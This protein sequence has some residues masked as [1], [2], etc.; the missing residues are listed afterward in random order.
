MHFNPRNVFVS[1]TVTANLF[2]SSYVGTISTLQLSKFSNGSYSLDTLSVNNVTTD[3]PSWLHKDPHNGILYCLNEGLSVVNGSISSFAVGDDGSLSLL[4]NE[5]TI[6]GPVSSVL[7]NGGKSLA[8]AHYSGASLTTHNIQADGTLAPLQTITFT[9][10]GPGPDPLK[11]QLTPHPHEAL[12]DPTENFIVVPDLGADLVRVF[13]IDPKTALLTEKTPY[14]APPASG[15]R[16][17]AFHVTDCNQTFFYL[18]S[19]L[20]NTVTSFAVSYENATAGM[21]FTK[22]DTHGIFGN[23]TTPEGAAAA[24]CLITPDGRHILTSARNATI[25]SIPQPPVHPLNNTALPSDTLQTWTINSS[26]DSENSTIGSL[27]FSQLLPAGGFFPRQM[28]M[29][30][31]GTL[32]AVALQRSARVA[33]VTRDTKTGLFGEFVADIQI[34]TFEDASSVDGQVTSVIWDEEDSLL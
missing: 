26:P 16:H 11:R 25:L 31:A 18:V 2:V 22:I 32:V 1:G 24:E 27:S 23:Q 19:E 3:N 15:P 13:S 5:L 20:G 8:A 14:T 7:F 6:N 10:P 4:G 21:T 17:G 29:N 30:K 33:I 9:M 28:S 12:L 34:G